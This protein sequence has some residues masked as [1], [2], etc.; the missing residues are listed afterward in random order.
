[1]STAVLASTSRYRLS[2]QAASFLKSGGHLCSHS[3]F[4]CG[5]GAKGPPRQLRIQVV[6][7]VVTTDPDSEA[8]DF[9]ASIVENAGLGYL[10][11]RGLLFIGLCVILATVIV[12]V[13]RLSLHS[14][15]LVDAVEVA[16]QLRNVSR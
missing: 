1:M 9:D 3:F 8:S 16:H 7:E 5:T 4:D 6:S 12:L 2:P 15:T 10:I 11:F 13:C 14:L